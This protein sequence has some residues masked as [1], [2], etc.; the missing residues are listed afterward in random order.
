MLQFKKKLEFY[1]QGLISFEDLDAAGVI[2]NDKQL[3]Q[4]DFWLHDR[5][6]YANREEIRQFLAKLSYPLYFLDFESMMPAIP[7]CVGIHPFAQIP[8]QYS[9][10]YIECDDGELQHREFLGESGKDP[11]RAL[12][13]SLCRDIPA[14]ACVTSISHFKSDRLKELAEAFPDLAEHLLAIKD[15]IVDLLIPFQKG[16][17][18]KKE[19]GGS[20]SIKSILPAICPD[21]PELDY[22]ELEGVHNGTEAMTVFPE[23]QYMEPEEQQKARQN[24]LAYCKLDTLA[25]VKVWE[26]LRRVAE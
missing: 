26:E 9:L 2:K 24:L 14:D 20:F 19:I 21:D 16:W 6:L 23:I 4:M 22:H 1:H 11:R 7:V 15:H 13:E 3:R 25:M 12:A 8:F 17:Y 18:Y 10:H 5:G